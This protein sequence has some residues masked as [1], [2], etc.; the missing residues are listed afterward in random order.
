MRLKDV[1]VPREHMLCKGAV[2]TSEGRYFKTQA[3]KEN[4]VMHYS[5]MLGYVGSERPAS[6]HTRG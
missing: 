1:R 6:G 5:T 4:P 2:V 3:K